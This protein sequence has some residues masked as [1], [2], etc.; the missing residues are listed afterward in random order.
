MSTPLKAT[1]GARK[2]SAATTLWI[3]TR[4]GLWSLASDDSRRA[5]KLAGPH[6]LG[7]I[8]HHAVVDPRDRRTLLAA[9]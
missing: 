8:V 7:H 1:T 9:A 6:F 4:K 2:K 3:A 5:W